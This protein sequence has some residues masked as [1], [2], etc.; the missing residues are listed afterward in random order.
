MLTLPT[1]NLQAYKRTRNR[2]TSKIIIQFKEIYFALLKKKKTKNR[3]KKTTATTKKLA[4]KRKK[5]QN[6]KTKTNR[7]KTETV[8]NKQTSAI[9]WELLFY[10]II[11]NKQS[12]NDLT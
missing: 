3:N 4:N 10:I 7:N 6:K 8:Q 2:Q 12:I 1:V 9:E 5:K 11:L